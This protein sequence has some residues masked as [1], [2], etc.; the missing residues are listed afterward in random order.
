MKLAFGQPISLVR[1][2]WIPF[3][4]Y[5]AIWLVYEFAVLRGLI[6]SAYLSLGFR[7]PGW[8]VGAS[9]TLLMNAGAIAAYSVFAV[10]WHRLL[11]GNDGGLA[12]VR[13]WPC[14]CRIGAYTTV[15][16]IAV[17]A[18][19]YG[20]TS[21]GQW[22]A[23]SSARSPSDALLSIAVML[24]VMAGLLVFG[25]VLARL[26]LVFPAAALGQPLQ[27]RTAWQLTRGNTWRL[28]MAFGLPASG[29]VA[30]VTGFQSAVPALFRWTSSPYVLGVPWVSLERALVVGLSNRLLA[31]LFFACV[32][33][34]AAVAYRELLLRSD[35]MVEVFA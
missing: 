20:L 11:A 15:L 18:I 22:G 8:W 26:S 19:G 12:A 28:G 25:V 6:F 1:A 3:C 27:L 35:R 32:G 14:L 23:S 2:A 5:T 16:S 33:A 4:A 24:C 21:I 31:Y 13:I 9:I 17:A 10:A 7:V 29:Y 34:V 30:V